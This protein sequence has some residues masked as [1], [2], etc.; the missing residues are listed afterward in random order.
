MMRFSQRVPADLRPNR[1]AE[2]RARLG[3]PEFDLT[4]SNPT[5]CDLPYPTDLLR[6]LVNPAGLRYDPDPLGLEGAR[7]AIADWY[8]QWNVH[9]DPQHIVLTASTSEAYG[10]L[11]KM[12]VDPGETI[13]VPTPS[14]PLF[15][16]LARLDGVGLTH[17]R[18]DPES[19]WRV[20]PATVAATPDDCRV[21]VAVHPNNPT[22]SFLHP[23]DSGLLTALCRRRCLPLVVDEVFLPYR[24][25]DTPGSSHTFASDENCLTFTLGG[26]SK[27][28]G[29][30]QLKLAWIVVNGP[31]SE[32]QPALDRL[33]YVADAYLSVST[34][35]ALAVP[36]VLRRCDV[37]CR[38]IR[39]RCLANLDRLLELAET[40][41]HVT[42]LEPDGGWSAV[43]RIPNVVDEEE[44]ALDL[45]ETHGVAVHPGFLFDFPSDGYVVV[46]LLPPEP[47][48]R[49]GIRR[50]LDTV[51]RAVSGTAG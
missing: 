50:L 27:A 15:E 8:R 12:L 14:Y 49:E 39:C 6:A 33:E 48:F 16:Q 29:L 41:P 35:V 18:L 47:V 43:L 22:G 32:V 44:L 20:D 36:E 19:R 42:V 46:S 11:L 7:R 23:D 25:R 13:L 31:D 24:L 40:A 30:P 37:V 5:R 28:L 4:E 2:L 1:L 45:L 9:V 34:P 38:A 17:Y 3:P 51:V 21:V 26:L 10:F